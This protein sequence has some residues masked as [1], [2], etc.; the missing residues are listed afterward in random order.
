MIQTQRLSGGDRDPLMHHGGPDS[1]PRVSVHS[2]YSYCIILFFFLNKTNNTKHL[3]MCNFAMVAECFKVIN[4][5]PILFRNIVIYLSDW[6]KTPN[7][8]P[9]VWKNS[10]VFFTSPR[11][12]LHSFPSLEPSI[13]ISCACLGAHLCFSSSIHNS[14][15]CCFA[16]IRR[17]PVVLLCSGSCQEK[18][19]DLKRWWCSEIIGYDTL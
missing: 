5:H 12:T 15:S 19:K 17:L 10:N 1:R 16:T 3:Y 6:S 7:L 13:L 8:S 18:G 11:P 14:P 2:N 9:C 4:P